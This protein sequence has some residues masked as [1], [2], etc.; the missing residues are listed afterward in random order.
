MTTGQLHGVAG[1]CAL[2]VLLAGCSQEGSRPR[3]EGKVTFQGKPL[4]GRTL[5]LVSEG[6]P[7]EFFTQRIPIL[8]DGS[9]SG[10]V[11]APGNYKVVIEESLAVQEGHASAGGT[12]KTIPPKYRAPATTD[13]VWTIQSGKNYQEFKLQE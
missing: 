12:S 6:A 11:P 2:L 9:F 10:E 13:L 7:G 3:V 1:A 4:G 8:A 5:T